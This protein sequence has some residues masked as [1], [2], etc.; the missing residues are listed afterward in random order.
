MNEAEE[1]KHADIQSQEICA[2]RIHPSLY[3]YKNHTDDKYPIQHRVAAELMVI[4]MVLFKTNISVID[5]FTI[6]IW[7]F[8]CFHGCHFSF[9]VRTLDLNKP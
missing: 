4:G 1:Y 7:I 8:A 2:E 5:N 6:E 9:R 3:K